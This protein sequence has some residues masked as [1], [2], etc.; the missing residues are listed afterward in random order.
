MD[1]IVKK[2]QTVLEIHKGLDATD[3]NPDLDVEELEAVDK[4]TA[5]AQAQS[6]SEVND[7]VSTEMVSEVHT[8]HFET[9]EMAL[10]DVHEVDVTHPE[11]SLKELEG[12][13]EIYQLGECLSAASTDTFPPGA[14]MVLEEASL[15]EAEAPR[16]DPR[17]AAG[18]EAEGTRDEAMQ[19]DVPSLTQ[20]EYLTHNVTDLIQVE[21]NDEPPGEA[22]EKQALDPEEGRVQAPEE[23]II[24]EDILAAET[25]AHEEESL[26]LT[27][28]NVE[29]EKEDELETDAARPEHVQEQEAP[30]ALQPSPLV[31]EEG[32]GQ[33]PAEEVQSE[34]LPDA[35]PG[36]DQLK[37][38][39][40]HLAEVSVEPEEP[41]DDLLP[42]TEGNVEQV[43]ASRTVE[44]VLEAEKAAS[45]VA[46]LLPLEH[47]EIPGD[48]SAVEA[49]TEEPNEETLPC[50]EANLE[51]AVPSTTQH[52]QEPAAL[53]AVEAPASDSAE[54]S[55][56]LLE[57]TSE[58]VSVAESEVEDSKTE[59]VLA[60]EKLETDPVEAVQA[61]ILDSEA[62]SLLPLEKEAM[63]EDV[64]AVAHLE[65]GD[66]PKPDNEIPEVLEAPTEASIQPVGVQEAVV[67]LPAVQVPTLDS[68]A[69]SLQPFEKEV[70]SEDASGETEEETIACSEADAQP[71]DAPKTSGEPE[72]LPDI[73]GSEDGIETIPLNRDNTE[74]M[75]T[76]HDQD[77]EILQAVQASRSDSEEGIP[78]SL[79][80]EVVSEEP[81][82][83]TTTPLAVK[84]EPVEASRTGDIQEPEEVQ[85]VEEATSDSDVGSIP[86]IEQ[87]VASEDVRE[88]KTISDD[89]KEETE[90][91]DTS[92]TAGQQD[93]LEAVETPAS[94]AEVGSPQWF[95]KEVISED[96]PAVETDKDEPE[97]DH[98]VEPEE[99][100]PEEAAITEHVQEPE[101]LPSDSEDIVTAI[102]ADEGRPM[103]VKEVLEDVEGGN[104]QQG[105]F[106]EGVPKPDV[107]HV[108]AS[109]TNGIESG[110]VAQADT[111]LETAEDQNTEGIPQDVVVEQENCIPEVVDEIQTLTAVSVS[112]VLEDTSVQVLENTV[113]TERL[114]AL[115][116]DTAKVTNEPNH[117]VQLGA[118]QATV[119]TEKE[120]ELPDTETTNAFQHAVVAQVVVC[121]YASV[122]I[123]DV[124]V[125][126]TSA[127]P[128]PSVSEVASEQVFKDELET[129]TP[130]L[131]D[132]AEE[133]VEGGG[134]AVTMHVPSVES[135]DNRRIQVQAVDA[136]VK[137]AETIQD[138]VLEAGVTEDKE[139][140][141][142]CQETVTKEEDFSAT[143][144][145]E[146]E[147][148][149]EELKVTI[150]DVVPHVQEHLPEPES[151]VEQ[152][153]V[154]PPEAVKEVVRGE[155][156]APEAT[157]D[158]RETF[159]E[160]Q[161]E[162][163]TG[164]SDVSA[165]EQGSKDL[166]PNQPE[167]SDTAIIEEKQDLE[168]TKVEQER[169]TAGVVVQEVKLDRMIHEE[170]PMIQSPT[171]T[172]GE[173]GIATPHNTGTISSI[174]NVIESPSSVSIEFKLNIQYG[175]ASLQAPDVSEVGVQAVEE[176]QNQIRR[177]ESE[178]QIKERAVQAA[179]ITE[180][181]A[182]SDST[183]RAVVTTP[184]VLMDI[185]IQALGE[186]KPPESGTS[187]VPA[188]E[189]MQTENRGVSQRHPVISV[190]S[191]QQVE[192]PVEAKEEEHEQDVWVDAQ[193]DI[194]EET[195]G[196][197]KE[198]EEFLEPCKGDEEEEEEE[199]E[200][201]LETHKTV[202]VESDEDFT[203]APESPDPE[204]VGVTTM[205]CD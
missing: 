54:V 142:V 77:E 144:E 182:A 188:A 195:E 36:T 190:A 1:T 158:N 7:S 76:E 72:V 119:E 61:A 81:R 44:E 103:D 92:T 62:A 74:S 98:G 83:E 84:S 82:D 53:D 5:S 101:V 112:L 155:V 16:N 133:K 63:S 164:V 192:E 179:G 29:P 60:P 135:E 93:V 37:Q 157:E 107:D 146:E 171:V 187:S 145:I 9:A 172:H 59:H 23:D 128:E 160:R 183:E 80:Q 147:L 86:P 96:I 120:S 85:A 150:G 174:S 111:S 156:E 87:E 18:T 17:V 123:P 24:S 131:K 99:R 40:G 108:I 105:I 140:I 175:R 177:D 162:A 45:E 203:V 113:L 94:G 52:V 34:D 38:T 79:E 21:D 88:Q 66:S 153:G 116:E 58:D 122:A 173:A 149:N 73:F 35:E 176:P 118:V 56:Q 189:T 2:G 15:A 205:E 185:H 26:A 39:G 42:L 141:D 19:Q 75:E 184:P 68:E 70:I 148:T 165:P 91:D 11:Q 159:R 194:R 10:D 204:A 14:D 199:E 30:E 114:A 121:K 28:V 78:V 196:P 97:Q 100:L 130:L 186:I 191:A 49:A 57:V 20:K 4:L 198:E 163:P 33:S 95:A 178:I 168:E 65:P 201:H 167:G 152:D 193:E 51:P 25:H 151:V 134:V 48:I 129:S 127:I 115:S 161:E 46:S 166:V 22:Q 64:A 6:I 110:V 124:L 8:E 50:T 67:L 154:H 109:V 137:S 71:G 169:C 200:R 55:V 132:E 27:E 181:A 41:E 106:I 104:A 90:A 197:R 117:A 139:V 13:D 125:Q 89:P 126:K 32:R 180:H 3:G 43:E 69:G 170:A 138:S 12:I 47:E 31:S 202:E 143:P 136:D 102:Q